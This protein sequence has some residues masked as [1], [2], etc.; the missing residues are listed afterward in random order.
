MHGQVAAL[1]KRAVH[2]LLPLARMRRAILGTPTR[3]MIRTRITTGQ[4][5]AI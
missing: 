2:A 3:L 1:G 5:L 4:I